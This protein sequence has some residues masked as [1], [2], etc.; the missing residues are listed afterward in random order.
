MDTLGGHYTLAQRGLLFLTFA[1]LKSA[2]LITFGDSCYYNKALDHFLRNGPTKVGFRLECLACWLSATGYLFD[3][4]LEVN[5]A[6]VDD[7]L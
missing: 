4:F 5:D 6:I 1:D 3:N 7:G 2:V